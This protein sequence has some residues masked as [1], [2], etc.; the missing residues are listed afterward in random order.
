MCPRLSEATGGG[1]RVES[2]ACNEYT[3]GRAMFGVIFGVGV[4]MY[5]LTAILL[6]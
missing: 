6:V 5:L 1:A 3:R 2:L 4:G